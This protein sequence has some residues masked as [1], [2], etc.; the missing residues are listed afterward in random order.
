MSKVLIDFFTEVQQ[1]KDLF[2]HRREDWNRF[3]G[4]QKFHQSGG[5]I[6]PVGET[7]DGEEVAVRK[8]YP[9]GA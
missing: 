6:A 3:S 4:C 7:K 5:R 1:V 2:L 8:K 9:P